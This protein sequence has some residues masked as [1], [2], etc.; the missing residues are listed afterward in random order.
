VQYENPRSK[1]VRVLNS[2]AQGSDNVKRIH[3]YIN[4][5]L[6]LSSEQTNKNKL[7]IKFI[8]LKCVNSFMFTEKVGDASIHFCQSL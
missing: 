7:A 6:K 4:Y 3:F 2:S 5:N 1:Y 8:F